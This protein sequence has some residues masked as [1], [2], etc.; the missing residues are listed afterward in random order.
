M[1]ESKRFLTLISQ[2]DQLMAENKA[3]REEIVCL[4]NR[5]SNLEEELSKYKTPK[6][7]S[8]S[9]IPSSK[10]PLN[11]PKTRS[12]R[13]KSEKTVGGQ[14][15]HKGVTLDFKTPTSTINYIP[16]YCS[17]CAESLE[18]IESK[19][20]ESRQVIDI[21]P[22]TMEIIEHKL[23]SK[24]CSCGKTTQSDFPTHVT[25]GISYGPR[26]TTMTAYYHAREFLPYKRL[27][28]LYFDFFN[29]KISEATL[30]NMVNRV[31]NKAE[32]ASNLILTKILA[33]PV[34]GADES[35]ININGDKQWMFVLQNDKATWMHCFESRSVSNL[36]ELFGHGLENKVLV[37]DCLA[38]YFKTSVGFHQICIAHLLRELQYFIDR[39]ECCWSK[40]LR[41]ILLNSLDLAK[42]RNCTHVNVFNDERDKLLKEFLDH[43]NIDLSNAPPIVNTF[44][45]RMNR[46]FDAVFLFLSNPQVPPDN[47]GS[48]R[49]IRNIKVKQKVSGLFKNQQSANI[50]ANIRSVIDTAIKN[51]QCIWNALYQVATI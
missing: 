19:F 29:L 25:P 48:E 21:P 49:A 23:F 20:I 15:N 41:L 33:S 1:K 40:K 11:I 28:E 10:D 50:Y 2:H 3:L 42:T 14:L 51:S 43:I 22:I 37:H 45:K 38:S 4:K 24:K 47:N 44:K 32:N 36:K 35:S 9:S 6:N 7:S 16:E 5:I 8:N 13:K 26:L 30:V 39:F 34:I 18:N 17:H 27:K 12:L 46:L 31:G